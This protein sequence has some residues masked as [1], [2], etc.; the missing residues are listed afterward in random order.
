[1]T[2]DMFHKQNNEPEKI[3]LPDADLLFW[4]QFFS[5][6]DAQR[7]FA[8]LT[9]NVQWEAKRIMMYGREVAVPRLSAWY[10][11]P[12]KDYTYS[13]NLHTALQWTPELLI[14]KQMVEQRTGERFNSVLCNLYRDGQDSVA[15]HSDDEPELGH[16]PAI[17]SLSFGETRIFHLRR[18]DDHKQKFDIELPSGSCLLMRGRT[19]QAWQHQIAKSSRPL[20][21]R[22]N[23]TFRWIT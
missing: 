17:A 20:H 3:S 23:L 16:E 12:S 14:L 4:P 13:G 18:A 8:D 5:N 15:W 11:D 6:D 22:I 2:L 1:M 7:W 9:A 19:Q 10:A 21:A